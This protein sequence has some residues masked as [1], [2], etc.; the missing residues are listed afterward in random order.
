MSEAKKS[1][2]VHGCVLRHLDLFSGIGGFALAAQMAGGY[3]TVGFCEIEPYCQKVLAKNFPDTPIHGDV[4]TLNG[5]E[6]G[7]IDI[8][9]AGYPCQPFS[10]AGQRKG[11]EDD[12]HLWPEIK[13]IVKTNRPSWILCENVAG[14]IT[15]GLDEVLFDLET[16]GYTAR[17]LVIPACAV[18]AAHRRDRVWIIANSREVGCGHG[19]DYR[20]E[21]HI[22]DNKN[23]DAKKGESEWEGR[24]CGSSETRQNV[25]NSGCARSE[26]RMAESTGCDQRNTGIVDDESPACIG[27]ANGERMETWL[28]EPPV[29]RVANGIPRRV[30]RLRGLGNGIVPQ[31]AAK[32]LQ[33]IYISHNT[34][35]RGD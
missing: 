22:Q 12:R 4:K 18:D 6:Y 30:D 7:T 17:P 27:Q 33:A 21:R 2:P 11:A 9:T 29:G 1:N 35:S 24:K 25:A 26:K 13:R 5:N 16:E 34:E 20:E 28:P 15:L 3:E 8:I 23:R 10:A 14:H 32:I 31:V 19:S